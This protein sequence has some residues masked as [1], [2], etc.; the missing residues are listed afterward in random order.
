VFARNRNCGV[1]D[2]LQTYHTGVNRFI[3]VL[4]FYLLKSLLENFLLQINIMRHMS[5]KKIDSTTMSSITK[6]MRILELG[7]VQNQNGTT[8]FLKLHGI[9]YF[10]CLEIRKELQQ[11]YM[12]LPSRDI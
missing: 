10:C 4:Q 9:N 3:F 12:M 7:H 5:R 2:L 1:A 6:L 11:L 8:C